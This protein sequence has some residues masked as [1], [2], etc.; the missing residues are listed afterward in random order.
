MHHH[1]YDDDFAQE[2]TVPRSFCVKNSYQKHTYHVYVDVFA[3]EKAVPHTKSCSVCVKHSHQKHVYH[4]YD[5]VFAQEKAALG[6][7]DDGVAHEVHGVLE[8]KSYFLCLSYHSLH[9][10]YLQYHSFSLCVHGDDD[11]DS[12]AHEVHHSFSLCVHDSDD[13]DDP[14]AHEVQYVLAKTS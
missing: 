2:K 10:L 13:D 8:K 12:A 4:V 9:F 1:V 11:D 14:V 3:R 5:G 6:D 7:D